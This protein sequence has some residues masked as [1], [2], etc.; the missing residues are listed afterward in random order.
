LVWK[1]EFELRQQKLQFFLWLAV[2]LKQQATAS[3]RRDVDSDHPY[4]RKFFEHG[5]MRETRCKRLQ[6]A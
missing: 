1:N 6:T 2:P 5:M 4:G 3:S